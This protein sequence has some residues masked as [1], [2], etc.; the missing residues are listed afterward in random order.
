MIKNWFSEARKNIWEN[1]LLFYSNWKTSVAS[2][3]KMNLECS[4]SK[5]HE[6]KSGHR[7]HPKVDGPVQNIPAVILERICIGIC[8]ATDADAALTSVTHSAWDLEVSTFEPMCFAR[9]E[10]YEL[11]HDTF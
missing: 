1:K 5:P 9:L 2:Y 10:E 3:G 4:G 11:Q 7:K 6:L 8:V